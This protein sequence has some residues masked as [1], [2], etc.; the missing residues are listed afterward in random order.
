VQIWPCRQIPYL[1]RFS[2]NVTV[3]TNPMQPA[4]DFQRR[5]NS[6]GDCP[7]SLRNAIEKL[8]ELPNPHSRAISVADVVDRRNMSADRSKRRRAMKPWGVSPVD[9]LNARQKCP[10]V[11]SN[12]F[13]RSA[14]LGRSPQSDSSNA[15]ARLRSKDERPPRAR[16]D[17]MPLNLRS[18][19]KM[20]AAWVSTMAA[21]I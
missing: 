6:V 5:L 7:N 12:S 17:A 4:H 11:M 3:P 1:H 21:L 16:L 9:C 13:A 14:R 2:V 19:P 18:R 15:D 8:L 10:G 20:A